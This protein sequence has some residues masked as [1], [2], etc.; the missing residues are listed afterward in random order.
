MIGISHYLPDYLIRK[1]TDILRDRSIICLDRFYHKKQNLISRF[2]LFLDRGQFIRK[3]IG[4]KNIL[5]NFSYIKKINKYLLFVSHITFYK[6]ID[7]NLMKLK[8]KN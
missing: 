7:N 4:Y 3:F 6:N 1:F 2:F 8:F 5:K